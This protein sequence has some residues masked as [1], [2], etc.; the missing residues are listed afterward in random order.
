MPGP[1]RGQ[2]VTRPGTG[3]PR[4]VTH[5]CDAPGKALGPLITYSWRANPATANVCRPG[6]PAHLAHQSS[7]HLDGCQQTIATLANQAR[8]PAWPIV[9]TRFPDQ[10]DGAHHGE[11]SD[12]DAAAVRVDRPAV[13]GREVPGRLPSVPGPAGRPGAVWRAAARWRG[14]RF[15][16]RVVLLV[17]PGLLTECLA[18]V[19]DPQGLL[20]QR[21]L[22][23]SAGTAPD[24]PLGQHPPRNVVSLRG[25][26]SAL[27]PRPT[28]R[29]SRR[30]L[31]SASTA[32]APVSCGGRMKGWLTTGSS[33]TRLATG[34]ACS[35]DDRGRDVRGD[36]GR[37]DLVQE[38]LVSESHTGHCPRPCDPVTDPRDICPS[39][40]VGARAPIR[41]CRWSGVMSG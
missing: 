3:F 41:L 8:Q 13:F 26:S 31:R 25:I 32:G 17:H 9:R 10:A 30:S 11:P 19:Q 24:I 23:A 38:H 16:V 4:R 29:I 28:S 22:I 27:R 6:F 37:V 18:L 12:A 40:V 1:A 36:L 14:W 33:L 2:P 20:Q 5:D 34:L 7:R 39:A 21:Y 15:P 35:C